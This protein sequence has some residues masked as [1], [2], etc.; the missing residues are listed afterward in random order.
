MN[1]KSSSAE[2]VNSFVLTV[3]NPNMGLL[4]WIPI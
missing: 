1:L 4:G 2:S 3:S